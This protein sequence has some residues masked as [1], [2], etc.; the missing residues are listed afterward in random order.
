MV[1][2]EIEEDWESGRKGVLKRKIEDDWESGREG[3]VRE[4]DKGK[5]FERDISKLHVL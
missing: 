5:E 1:E 2:K 3:V 4:I